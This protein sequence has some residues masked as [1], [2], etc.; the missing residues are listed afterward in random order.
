MQDATF[1]PSALR[2]TA[3]AN[4]GLALVF[5]FINANLFGQPTRAPQKA[6]DPASYVGKA[7]PTLRI[8]QWHVGKPV[9]PAHL[10]GLNFV[11]VLMS[12]ESQLFERVAPFLESIHRSP[13]EG[14]PVVLVLSKERNRDIEK[15]L[16]RRGQP[17]KFMIATDQQL[18]M[19]RALNPVSLPAVYISGPD[20]KVAA[21]GNLDPDMQQRLRKLERGK[22]RATREEAAE[23]V[24]PKK[25]SAKVVTQL[26]KATKR[27]K[28]KPLIEAIRKAYDGSQAPSHPRLAAAW[29][30]VNELLIGDA[31]RVRGLTAKKRYNS[32]RRELAKLRSIY[33]EFAPASSVL[34]KV[35]EGLAQTQG[36]GWLDEATA[37]RDQGDAE[38]AV[39]L[40]EKI[41]KHY[42]STSVGR[43]AQKLLEQLQTAGRDRRS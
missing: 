36:Q 32:A 34:N 20:G 42:G 38:Q 7:L 37:A 30:Q 23:H 1:P 21:Q 27:G 6:P 13:A 35:L 15:V 2:G 26:E 5:V 29:K 24:G 33:L 25:L 8:D 41:K 11:L 16:S 18:R 14:G 9:T 22:P 43:K 4:W 17:P 3:A 31:K 19:Y 39:R 10:R 28:P 12:V 40:L